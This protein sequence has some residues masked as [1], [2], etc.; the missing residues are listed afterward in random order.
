MAK[1]V[2]DDIYM[3]YIANTIRSYGN[4][5]NEDKTYKTSEMAGGISDAVSY[6]RTK[7]YESGRNSGYNTGYTEGLNEGNTQ[8]YN[9]GYT[10]GETAGKQAE[11]LAYW[12]AITVNGTRTVW[13]YAFS[14][15]DYSDI[16]FVK[17]VV[18]TGSAERLF[19]MYLGS[20][21]PRKQDIDM[22]NVTKIS[23]GFSYIRLQNNT[24]GLITIPD[25]GIPALDDYSYTYYNSDIVETIEIVRCHEA[26]AFYTSAF[27]KCNELKNITFEGVIGRDLGMSACPLSVASLKNII[28]CLK[29][30]TGVTNDYGNSLE[31]TYTLTLKSSAFSALEA[32][33]A[34]AEYNGTA[35][36]WR[37]LIDNKK[38]NL[39]LS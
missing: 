25:Y 37:E 9:A 28:T 20:K 19:Y 38:W 35:C 1:K 27:N 5:D 39:T 30:Y 10:E 26:T 15:S 23:Y 32:E 4:P 33:G 22:T 21:L 3:T 8:G 7:S 16:E 14:A 17:P 12:K 24:N 34:T 18:I 31:Y 6:N 13:G 36:T 29:D 11:G 2:F